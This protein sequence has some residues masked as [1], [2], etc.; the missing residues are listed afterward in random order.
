M[1][2]E[3]RECEAAGAAG[4]DAGL[5]RDGTNVEQ[6]GSEAKNKNGEDDSRDTEN[7]ET[8]SYRNSFNYKKNTGTYADAT[9]GK[10]RRPTYKAGT[11]DPEA[12][13]VTRSSSRK[14]SLSDQGKK[15]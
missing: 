15:K 2:V 8:P 10:G 14:S 5:P 3:T 9:R 1:S 11:T 4:H 13:T 7:W 12:H 6:H